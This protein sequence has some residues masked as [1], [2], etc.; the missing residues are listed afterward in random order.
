[1]SIEY[2]IAKRIHFR[3]DSKSVSRPAVRIATI[4]IA[5]G[6]AVMLVSVAVVIGFKSEIRNKAI[7]FGGH[8]QIGNYSSNHTYETSPISPDST[9]IAQVKAL[10]E[11]KSLQS[12][13]TKPG[14]VKTQTEFQ[15]IVMKGVSPESDMD[16]FKAN[17]VEG[18]FDGFRSDSLTNQVL[19]SSYIA[20]RLG[21]KLGDSFFA[22][23]IQDQVRARKFVIEAIYNTNFVEYDKMFVVADIRHIQQLNGWDS[24]QVSGLEIVL[25]DFELLDE[26]AYK[27]YNIS[28]NIDRDETRYHVQTIRE[29]N[30]QIFAW[31]ELIDMNVWVILFLM[32]AVA[33]FNMISGLLILI[34]ERTNMIG[35]LK[36]LGS[37]NWSIRKIFMYHSFFLISKGMFWGN[38]IGLGLCLIQ[39]YTHIIALDPVSYY[40]SYVPISINLLYIVLLNVGTFV[41][42]ILMMVG[43]SYLITKISPAKIIR[44]E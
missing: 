20:Q 19:V 23:F 43:P 16:F 33:G 27:I 13:A 6:I 35:V 31:L 7:G 12:F 32:L 38:I 41:A 4:A 22:Y 17:L 5:L 39:Y 44:F 1:M 28:N 34:L 10:P 3:Q 25:T 18:S 42:S 21:M 36:A 8:V 9:L 37:S 14:I 24:T 11:V 40:V 29:L 30:S 15:G 2:F 26:A